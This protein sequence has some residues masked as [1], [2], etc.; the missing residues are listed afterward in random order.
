[1]N[2]VIYCRVSSRDQVEGTSLQSQE[3][4]CHE[5]TRRHNLTVSRVFLEEG[6][7]AKFADRTQLLALMNYCKDKK[8][9]IEAML[10]WKVD[11]FAR[12]VEDHYAI[13]AA[14]RKLGVRVISVTEPIEADPNGKLMEA[15]LA[16]FAQFDNDVR[17][18]RA[19]Q[20]MQ[21]RL[22][23]GI[24]P[25]KPPLGYL[26]AKM[27]K[28]TKP[29]SPDP[30]RF[31]HLR[32][33][34][35][36]FVSGLHTKAAILRRLRGW[37]VTG[38]TG[39]PL[40]AQTIDYIFSNPFYA[41]IV[42]DP[43]TGAEYQGR[44]V[45]MVSQAEFARVQEIVGRRSRSVAHRRFNP[46]FPI[47]GHVR[48]PAC[49]WAMT[50]TFAQ[51]SHQRYSYYSCQ[52]RDCRLRRKSYAA[53]A[54]HREFT[55]FIADR[56][57]PS[58]IVMATLNS[59]VAGWLD[60][61]S[62]Q[63]GIISRRRAEISK[64]DRQLQELISMRV[65]KLVSTD[66]FRS[67]RDEIRNRL[68]RARSNE[69]DARVKPLSDEEISNL[70]YWM[71]DLGALWRVLPMEKKYSFVN[72]MFGDGYVFRTIRT[73]DPSLVF[74]VFE[75]SGPSLSNVVPLTREKS[76]EIIVEIRRFLAIVPD[77]HEH[78]KQAA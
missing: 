2:T 28:K 8:N 45:A 66:E 20:G 70:V 39:R 72:L 49:K 67:Q 12:N 50:A 40:S 35:K 4:A 7:S 71:A 29:D 41:G 36:L 51:G 18:L 47:R 13:K 19:T 22:K 60:N 14:L 3:A 26:P 68:I 17:A 77:K 42:R 23:D 5:Y 52:Q 74:R 62:Q 59:V 64:L 34:W 10:V 48:C 21:Q 56:S 30:E 54:V 37:G 53:A 58:H 15:I 76:N 32:Q 75:A 9:G 65:D 78:R 31:E 38:W 63:K 69:L 25:W 33:A 55:E 43:W 27:G 44:H 1:M 16:G 57:V 61:T 24:Y 46:D 11:R 73:T 6:E